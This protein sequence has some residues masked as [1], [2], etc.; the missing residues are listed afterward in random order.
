MKLTTGFVPT[1]R[2]VFPVLAVALW[3]G[4]LGAAGAAAAL[5]VHGA[6][7]WD[8]QARL[9]ER[10]AGLQQRR[11]AQERAGE[12]APGEADARQLLRR[13]ASVNDMLAL[14]G[15]PTSR[16]LADLESLIPDEAYLLTFSHDRTSGRVELVVSSSSVEAATAFLE[17]LEDH[18]AFRSVT[19]KKKAQ[20][21]ENGADRV[22]L[23][24]ELQEAGT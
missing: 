12:D 8:D 6:A 10:L 3:T 19:L 2:W 7:L 22:I 4:A 20:R 14:A 24:L 15:V 9:D 21:T 13:V 23:E 16:L 5:L 1:Y 11:A 17:R 18:P